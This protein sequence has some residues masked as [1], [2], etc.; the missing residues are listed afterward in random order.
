[1][2]PATPGRR[3]LPLSPSSRP[4]GAVSPSCPRAPRALKKAKRPDS[5]FPG[6]TGRPRG[7]ALRG[8]RLPLGDLLNIVVLL[9]AGEAIVGAEGQ[10]LAV[11][12][13]RLRDIPGALAAGLGARQGIPDL[14]SDVREARLC[15]PDGILGVRRLLARIGGRRRRRRGRNGR[16][17]RRRLGIRRRRG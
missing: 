11:A 14:C 16:G 9:V 5:P 4:P 1:A 10:E 17:G 12:G 7:D 6:L 3:R 15:G 2:P 8:E 13:E